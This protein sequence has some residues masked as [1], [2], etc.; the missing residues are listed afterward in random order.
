MDPD[1]EILW[2]KADRIG[3]QGVRDLIM[4]LQAVRHQHRGCNG[5]FPYFERDLHYEVTLDGAARLSA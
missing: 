2:Q 4:A 1:L 5:Y 3:P